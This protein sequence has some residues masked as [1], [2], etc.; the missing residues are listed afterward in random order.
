MICDIEKLSKGFAGESE[1]LFTYKHRAKDDEVMQARARAQEQ[2]YR[3]LLESG[4]KL[5]RE[6]FAF[7]KMLVDYQSAT[8]E[9]RVD[10]LEFYFG[11][12][13]VEIE[14]KGEG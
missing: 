2:S 7:K 1:N 10:D 13:D 6:L 14:P 11:T 9:A 4:R 8:S 12:K 5:V 3:E